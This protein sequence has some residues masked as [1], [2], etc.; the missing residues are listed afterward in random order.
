[1]GSLPHTNL[2]RFDGVCK[3]CN[4][5]VQFLIRQDKQQVLQFE[6]LPSETLTGAGNPLS[7]VMYIRQDRTYTQSSAI[8]RILGDLGGW[9]RLSQI[10]WLIPRP[11]RDL[12]YRII[13]RNRYR[14]WGRND[15][16]RVPHH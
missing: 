3:L 11:L 9:W 4:G 15:S 2:V 6:P 10:C 1:M 12:V 7:T 14:W 8:L 13:S 5:F 16:C